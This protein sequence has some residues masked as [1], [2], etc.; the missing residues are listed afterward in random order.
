[1]IKFGGTSIADPDRMRRA[2]E[3]VT[4][5]TEAGEQVA[6]VLSAMGD[7]TNRLLTAAYAVANGGADPQD[8]YRIALQGEQNSVLMMCAALKSLKVTP[9]PFI[10]TD[11]ENWPIIVDSDD[12]SP[13]ATT[14]INEERSITLRSEKTQQRF[15]R[16]VTPHLRGGA[17]PVIAG[18][19]ALSSTEQLVT[20]GRGGSDI[21]AFIAG[22]Y[23]G[24]DEVIIVTD[25]EG[26]LDAD[27]R[28]AGKN[29]KLI[30]ELS[31]EDLEAMSGAGS[32]VIH[33]RALRFKTEEIKARIM[34]YKNL[35]RLGSSG[36]TILGSSQASIFTNPA[37]LAVVTLVGTNLARQAGLLAE[38]ADRLSGIPINSI[39]GTDRFIQI[40]LD[41]RRGEE[42]YS[43]LHNFLAE[44]RDAFQNITIKGDIGEIRL[45][46]SSFIDEPGVLSEITGLI[47]SRRINV[48][49]IVTMLSDIYIYV[50]WDNIRDAAG[51]LSAM[52]ETAPTLF[53]EN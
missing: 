35:D 19:F 33:P 16:Y 52:V 42:A 51:A 5:L 20:L 4:R 9:V 50:H 2:A 13:I 44:H 53:Q 10:P 21:T 12:N 32:R 29:A 39:V 23:I 17:V 30:E 47:S 6:V 3:C 31:V 28:M 46:S 43:V 15:R 45:R 40:Y 8:V 41:D 34:D 37:K 11:R 18:F 1:V 22:R 27:P 24:A 38:I 49:E 25:V 36:T 7:D 48:L 14:K 26:V